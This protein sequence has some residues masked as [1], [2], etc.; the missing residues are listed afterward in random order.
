MFCDVPRSMTDM[1]GEARLMHRIFFRCNHLE[2]LVWSGVPRMTHPD[3]PNR[4]DQAYVLPEDGAK[5][6][7]RRVNGKAGIDGED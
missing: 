2:P 3:R 1:M 7:A 5:L 6:K 4:P